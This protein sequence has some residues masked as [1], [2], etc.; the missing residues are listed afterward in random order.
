MK[1]TGKRSLVLYFLIAL[2]VAGLG[3]FLA[4][5][6]FQGGEWAVQPFNKHITQGGVSGT[7][8]DRDNT[9]LAQS[10]NGERIY[11][12]DPAV[13]CAMLQ[14]VGDTRGYISTSVQYVYRAPLSGYNLV[15]GL[16]SPTGGG[17]GSK[18]QLTLDAELCK[19]AYNAMNGRKGSVLVY[20][21]KTGEIVCMVSSP[22]LDPASPPADLDTDETGKYD[23]VYLNNVLSGL[24]TPGSTF[25]IVTAAAAIENISN[26]DEKT[27]V[28]NGSVV[29]N[30][31]KINCTGT[32]GQ[33]DFKTALARSCNVAFGELSVE[34]GSEA[35]QKTAEQLGFGERY[36]IDGITTAASVYDVEDATS[37]GMAW[38]GIGQYTDLANPY[39]MA[40]LM[41]AIANGGTPVEPYFIKSV[42]TSF[43]LVTQSGH[44]IQGDSLM[45]AQTAER[46][47]GYM[48]NN[49]TSYY[50]ESL[51]PGLEICAKTGTAEVGGEKDPSAWIVGFSQRQDTPY[52]FVV[53][54]EEGGSGIQ[55]AGGV[56]GAVL[57]QAAK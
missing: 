20:N 14:T 10:S 2:F 42:T 16:Y 9:V 44:A 7:I 13:R 29:I 57:Q 51:F 50:G 6:A 46:L 32:H 19:T 8:T 54:V 40:R 33:I 37:D 48:R 31:N 34:L 27:F 26:L 49:V 52:A 39:H 25:K 35:M 24:Y 30:G 21:Y 3:F 36:S 43:G 56:A 11:N 55:A 1:T 17:N 38:S 53:V 45:T 28:C 41:G 5:F 12:E 4:E 47:K 23:G 15:T 22:T 18:I